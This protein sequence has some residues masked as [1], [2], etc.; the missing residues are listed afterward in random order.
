VLR[1]EVVEVIENLA[2]AFRKRK[3]VAS[4]AGPAIFAVT[5]MC[6]EE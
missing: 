2:L 6:P 5:T 3:H 4:C 1:D